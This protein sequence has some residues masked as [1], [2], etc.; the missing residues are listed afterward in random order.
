MSLAEHYPAVVMAEGGALCESELK[1][2]GYTEGELARLRRSYGV[3]AWRD[4]FGGR[5]Y[6]K[7]QFDPKWRVITGVRD[8]LRIFRSHDVLYVMTQFI[9]RRDGQPS[10]LR[11]IRWGRANR[12]SELARAQVRADNTEPELSPRW[13]KELKRRVSEMTDPTRHVIASCLMRSRALVYDL[14]SHCYGLGHVSKTSL[15]KDRGV[16]LAVARHLGRGQKRTDLQVLRVRPGAKMV[17]ALEKAR[18]AFGRRSFL[19]KF[20]TGQSTPIFVPITRAGSRER[21]ADA[22]LF[23]L[24]NQD[25]LLP[26][27][28]SAGSRSNAVTAL[29]RRC[30]ISQSEANAILDLRFGCTTRETINQLRAELQAAV[31]RPAESEFVLTKEEAEIVTMGA[32]GVPVLKRTVFARKKPVTD[33]LVNRI[34]D[35]LSI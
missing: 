13:R 30:S 23:A 35:E 29:T 26:L 21:S 17:R 16:A 19:P 3:L 15:V 22:M 31:R 32:N 24:E 25:R 20:T 33:E 9:I 6:P 8:V 7:W 27:I 11:L 1:A 5:H 12:A 14:E 4:R 2:V 18:P 34:R 28:R 10:L